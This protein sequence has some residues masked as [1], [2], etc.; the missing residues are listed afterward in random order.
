MKIDLGFG[1]ELETMDSS[2]AKSFALRNNELKLTQELGM[3][4]K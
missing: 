2:Y 3:K 4:L 1:V